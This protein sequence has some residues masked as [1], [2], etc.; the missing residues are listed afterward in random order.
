MMAKGRGREAQNENS[1]AYFLF[2]FSLKIRN[3]A[4]IEGKNSAMMYESK[5]FTH[6]CNELVSQPIMFI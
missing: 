4:K 1:F 3:R 5:S 6:E 2:S